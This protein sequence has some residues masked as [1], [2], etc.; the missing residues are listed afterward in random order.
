MTYLEV[1]R[2][3]LV[4]GSIS[5]TCGL[6]AQAI[7]IWRTKSAK[8]FSLALVVALVVNEAVWL[9]YGIALGEWPI[10]A[11]GIANTPAVIVVVAGFF[12]YCK[13]GEHHDEHRSL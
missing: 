5:I 7:K 6:Y 4:I 11:I 1:S 9:N 12:Q 2:V 10:I 8:D 3:V 13:G